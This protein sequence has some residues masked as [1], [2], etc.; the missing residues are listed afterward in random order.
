VRKVWLA[1]ALVG[2]TMTGF[3][4][5][6]GASTTEGVFTSDCFQTH[7]AMDD[8]IVYPGK[9]GASHL[10]E[11][12]GNVTTDANSTYL[13]MTAGM[14]TCRNPGDTAGYWAPALLD[15][16]GDPIPVRRIKVYYR[17]T[18]RT[19]ANV[20]SFPP[21]FRMIA[22][23]VGTA[24]VY[25]GWNCDGTDLSATSRIDCSGQTP[26][27]TYVRGSVIFPMCGQVGPG[28]DIVTD[29]PD[30]RS[31]AAY[32]DGR[33]GCPADHPVQLPAIKLNMRFDVSNCIEAECHLASD[34]SDMAPGSSLHADFWNTWQQDALVSLVSTKL[35]A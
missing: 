26:G 1:L 17:D 7:R 5:L 8:P 35:N 10:H 33:N 15:A 6:G 31:H 4:T 22:G 29:S 3:A 2:V 16:N 20:I 14:T 12:F 9:P 21:D 28:G 23:G 25:A 32:G 34:M 18:P 13:S 27:H 30:H 24:G 11:F 19:A